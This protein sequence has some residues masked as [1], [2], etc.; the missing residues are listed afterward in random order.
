MQFLAHTTVSL[1][2][3]QKCML[4]LSDWN[5][6]FLVYTLPRYACFILD[7]QQ[8]L[9]IPVLDVLRRLSLPQGLNMSSFCPSLHRRC[10]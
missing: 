4:R 7:D 6:R 3:V 10:C 1:D 5:D 2:A 8:P 9:S